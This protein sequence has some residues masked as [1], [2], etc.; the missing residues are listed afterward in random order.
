MIVESNSRTTRENALDCAKL[1]ASDP[2]RKVLLTSDFHMFRAV[3]CFRKVGLKVE[4]RPIPDAG[5]RASGFAMRWSA[6]LDLTVETTKIGYYFVRGW[7]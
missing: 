5:K 6:F 1:V 4:P 7:I 3:R 2:G